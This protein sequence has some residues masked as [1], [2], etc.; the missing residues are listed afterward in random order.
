[1]RPPVA[2]FRGLLALLALIAGCQLPF[3][4]ATGPSAPQPAPDPVG[5]SGAGASL[6][7][8]SGVSG[9]GRGGE[10]VLGAAFSPSRAWSHLTALASFG[11]RNPGS[12]GNAKARTYL[13]QQLQEFGLEPV[14]RNLNIRV[15]DPSGEVKPSPPDSV[16][17][18]AA[19]V[20]VSIPGTSSDDLFVLM[21][22]YD[23]ASVPG[24]RFLGVNDGASGSAVLLEV[25]RVLATR[26]LPYTVE[27]AFL[28]GEAPF[29]GSEARRFQSMGTIALMNRLQ[30]D[31]SRVRL[32]VFVNRVGDADLQ[33]ARSLMS[34]RAYRQEFWNVARRTGYGDVFSA[35]ADFVTV[36]PRENLFVRG[37][38]RRVVTIVD[39]SFGGD[40][41]P[42]LYANSEDDNLDRCSPESLEAVGVVTLEALDAISQRLLKIDRFAASPTA[43]AEPSAKTDTEVGDGAA[44]ADQR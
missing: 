43:S 41:S 8:V 32:G 10:A 15:N 4:N 17:A 1:M 20:T 11:P 6:A 36:G 33:I 13:K 25:A 12:E 34:H 42:G 29:E 24:I 38:F 39:V 44:A 9:A 37:G 35:D 18:N 14:V 5:G 7:R 19:N 2:Q 31:L 40:Q 28:D 30:P 26:P 3:G 16:E 22:P 27:I 23:S 21:A